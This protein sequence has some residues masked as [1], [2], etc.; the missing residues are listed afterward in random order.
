MK[1]YALFASSLLLAALALPILAQQSTEPRPRPQ[2]RSTP[3]PSTE[4]ATTPAT[5]TEPETS[6]RARQSEPERQPARATE[7]ERSEQSQA[8]G[9]GGATNTNFHFDMKETPASVTHHEV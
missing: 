8:G 6:P 7:S 1:P 4:P 2:R 9:L 3:P 5:A